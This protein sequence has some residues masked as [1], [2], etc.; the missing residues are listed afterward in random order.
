MFI[1]ATVNTPAIQAIIDKQ[2][3]ESAAAAA[4]PTNATSVVNQNGQRTTQ[5]SQG[6]STYN[7]LPG[8]VFD[9]LSPNYNAV[10]ANSNGKISLSDLDSSSPTGLGKNYNGTNGSGSTASSIRQA[11]S[12]PSTIQSVSQPMSY[13]P[14]ISQSTI[15]QAAQ[16][17]QA[18]ADALA[19]LKKTYD[20]QLSATINPYKTAQA[21]IPGQ[22]TT[23]NNTA[24][25][26]G[27]VNAQHI[28]NA[29]AQMGLLQSGES[30]SQQLSNDTSTA[31]N[32]NANNL[33]GQQLDAGYNDKIALATAQNATDY[34][35]EAYQYGRD[36]TADSQWN[37]TFD[38]TKSQDAI[39]N[40]LAQQQVNNQASQFAQSFGLSQAQFANTVNQQGIQNAYQDKTFAQ[41]ADQ[42]A[43][44]MGLSR[45]QYASGLDQWAKTFAQT[46]AQDAIKNAQADATITG[47]YNG[48]DTLAKQAQAIQDAQFN[49]TLAAD[50]AYKNA[51]LAASTAKSSSG[52]KSVTAESAK[53]AQNQA[54]AIVNDMDSQGHGE[55][56]ILNYINSNAADLANKGVDLVALKKYITTDRYGG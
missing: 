52:S 40:A 54:I 55:T 17:K 43:Q 9:P 2:T 37:Q 20:N 39:K 23:L 29:L 5:Y 31:N 25:S 47:T 26:Q 22:I 11:M 21:A 4:K 46:Q 42:F 51:A 30:A 35:K 38:Y 7:V 24:S 32:I 14:I 49:A 8:S 6:N 3:R 16:I 12:Q 13:Q 50:T 15:D 48:S 10:V 33:Q 27:M 19:E 18:Q 53:I 28:R 1:L 36:A 41:A 45:D 34:N 44:Q 56:D